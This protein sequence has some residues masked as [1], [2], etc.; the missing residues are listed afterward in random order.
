M[1]EVENSRGRSCFLREAA[2]F[3]SDEKPFSDKRYMKTSVSMKDGWIPYRDDRRSFLGSEAG[4]ATRAGARV[5]YQFDSLPAGHY[6]V[7]RYEAG[8]C[9]EPERYDLL[10]T[11][12]GEWI[13]PGTHGWVYLETVEQ[14]QDGRVRYVYK[15]KAA[16]DRTDA[17]LLVRCEGPSS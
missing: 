15:A 17:L 9:L 1:G 14:K 10:N 8:D 12:T 16:G 4:E 11:E 3:W 2:L 6:Q 7:F 5:I 13:H